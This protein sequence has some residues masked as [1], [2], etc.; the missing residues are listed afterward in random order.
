[1]NSRTVPATIAWSAKD[2]SAYS[3]RAFPDQAFCIELVILNGEHHIYRIDRENLMQLFAEISEML[4]NSPI[5]E[6]KVAAFT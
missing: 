5:A 4:N 6:I 1:M 3:E 2:I